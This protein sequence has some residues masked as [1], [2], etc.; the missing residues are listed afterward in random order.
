MSP[1]LLLPLLLLLLAIALPLTPATTQTVP[2]LP[3]VQEDDVRCLR[4][5]KRHFRDPNARLSSWTFA[6]TSAGAICDFS[7]VSCW[8]PQE[9]RVIALELSGYGLHG[10]LPSHL[11]YCWAT[12]TLDLSNN[13]LEGPIPP[14]LCD[15]LPYL[16]TLD[17]SGNRLSGPMPSE[18]ANCV[19][20]NSLKLSGNALSGKIPASLSRLSRLR[21][22]DLSHNGDN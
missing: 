20:L 18:L 11:K 16:V 8:H 15:W 13:S 2:A 10:A 5:V 22:L 7:G 1:G 19:Y 4:G 17:L 12:T 9:S 14:A 6:N 3:V 21:T